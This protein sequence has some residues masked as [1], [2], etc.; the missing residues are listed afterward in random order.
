MLT[1]NYT[2]NCCGLL[3]FIVVKPP[4]VNFAGSLTI[5]WY[6]PLLFYGFYL[7]GFVVIR[8]VLF[9]LGRNLDMHVVLAGK[10]QALPYWELAEALALFAGCLKTS[11]RT[12]TADETVSV[13]ICI[14][15]FAING[16]ISH[17]EP[18]KSS[19]SCV[20]VVVMPVIFTEH[21]L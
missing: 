1:A 9:G 3:E 18:I 17:A 6:L 7:I 15:A 4:I 20:M 19:T 16:A 13:S 12:S 14:L 8:V 5:E 10:E 2:I 21:A 11:A